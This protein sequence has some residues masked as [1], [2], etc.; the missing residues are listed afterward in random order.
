MLDV[1]ASEFKRFKIGF[2][3]ALAQC[4]IALNIAF[5]FDHPGEAV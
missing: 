1:F 2:K 3:S 4:R 5:A